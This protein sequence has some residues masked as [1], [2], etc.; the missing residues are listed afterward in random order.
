MDTFCAITVVTSSRTEAEEAIDAG[1]AEIQKLE[2]LLNYFSPDSEIT[3]LNRASGTKPVKVS[4]ETL[5]IVQKAV[6]VSEMSGGAFDPSIAPLIRLWNFSKSKSEQAIPA[7]DEIRHALTLVDFTKISINEEK[8]EIFLE[9]QGME[10]D[11]GGIAKGYAAD[12]AVHAIKAKG[13]E[14]ALVAIAGDIRGFGLNASR[15]PWRVGIQ[16]PRPEAD[17]EK[18][19]EDVFASLG[20][21]NSAISTSGDYQRFFMHNG[22]RYHHIL[23]SK[24]GYSSVSGLISASVIAPE[25]YLA[26]GLSTAVFVLGVD[27]GMKL[28]ESKGFDAVLVDADRKIHITN[29]LR[30]KLDIMNSS[31]Q[32]MEE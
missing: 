27:K 21:D 8:S 20:L 4:N 32:L 25:G 23:D 1:F 6:A 29:N 31:Y 14:S 9:E 10:L 11:L 18:P 26:D 28:L 30:G 15:R 12:K 22:I 17:S 24:T 3:A 19:W 7:P 16:N 2:T 5:E 13:I